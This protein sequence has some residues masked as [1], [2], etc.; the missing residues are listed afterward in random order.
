MQVGLAAANGP[1]VPVQRG[2]TLILRTSFHTDESSED[3]ATSK[4]GAKNETR[5][6]GGCPL[7]NSACLSII[8]C[9]NRGFRQDSR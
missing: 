2:G 7:S 9:F 3:E 1:L 6:P 5:F 4:I 8:N